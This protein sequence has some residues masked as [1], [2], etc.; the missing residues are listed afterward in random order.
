MYNQ[1]NWRDISSEKPKNMSRNEYENKVLLKADQ[2]YIT[3]YGIKSSQKEIYEDLMIS[4]IMEKQ[5]FTISG[6]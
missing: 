6:I 1:K 3:T 4:I 2:D 5:K